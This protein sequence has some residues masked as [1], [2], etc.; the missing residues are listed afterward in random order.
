MHWPEFIQGLLTHSLIS[1]K[2]K[3]QILFIKYYSFDFSELSRTYPQYFVLSP[4]RIRRLSKS[5]AFATATALARFTNHALKAIHPQ[6][7]ATVPEP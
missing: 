4:C 5:T 6:T 7:L 2:K 1:V 3:Q